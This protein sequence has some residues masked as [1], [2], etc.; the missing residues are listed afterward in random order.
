MSRFM[1]SETS[2]A[3]PTTS[4]P[5]V[6]AVGNSHIWSL[7]RAGLKP[8]AA[9]LPYVLKGLPFFGPKYQPYWSGEN[10]APNHDYIAGVE[11]IISESKPSMV[12]CF[13]ASN[14]MYIWGMFGATPTFDFVIPGRED[15]DL[16]LLIPGF[17]PR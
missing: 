3:D 5:T 8:E 17:S 4:K 14:F 2:P 12:V 7:V 15:L 1:E 9:A 10:K 13:S 16:Y 6:V 11:K